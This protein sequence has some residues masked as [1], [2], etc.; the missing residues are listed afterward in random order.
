MMDKLL[1]FMTLI[2]DLKRVKR[3]GW[4][5]RQVQEPE[6]VADHMYRMAIL[7]FLVDPASSGLNKDRC[8]KISLVHDLAECIV[9]DLTPQDNIP[10][11][12]K[13]KQEM[14]AMKQIC[15]LVP[16]EV[17]QELYEL[18]EDYEF[19]RSEEAKFVKDLDKFEMILQAQEYETLSG[20]PGHLQEFFDSTAGKFKTELVREWV[21]KL[22]AER[23]SQT[24]T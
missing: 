18:W 8:I 10:K 14:D 9:G 2:G 17:G 20:C 23:T 21:K 1:K 6:S 16:E 11:A 3:A 13:Q 22:N 7:S 24:A 12:E 4:V 19:Q 5:L 15:S